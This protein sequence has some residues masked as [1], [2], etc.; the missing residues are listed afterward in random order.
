MKKVLKIYMWS[1]VGTIATPLLLFLFLFCFERIISPDELKG[2]RELSEEPLHI[3]KLMKLDLPDTAYV[4]SH[5]DARHEEGKIIYTHYIKFTEELSA[6]DVEEMESRCVERP[7][8][9]SKQDSLYIYNLHPEGSR[10]DVTCHLYGDH[11]EIEY[12][13]YLGSTSGMAR[14][15]IYIAL[16]G[17]VGYVAVIL[18]C[19]LLLWGLILL[20]I[21]LVRRGKA[22]KETADDLQQKKY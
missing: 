16:M 11:C 21:W 14:A 1:W 8:L 7:L 18:I 12:I 3:E 4:D 22:K 10:F 19:I 20:I 2:V 13:V 5:E 6:S 17:F 15:L 9:W